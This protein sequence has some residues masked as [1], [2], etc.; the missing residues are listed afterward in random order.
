METI[1][2][3]TKLALMVYAMAAAVSLLVAGVIRLTF[4]GIRLHTAR[5]AA[6]A[7]ASAQSSAQAGPKSG[8]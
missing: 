6:A 4:A 2:D 5:G 8:S 3:A 1:W 7:D